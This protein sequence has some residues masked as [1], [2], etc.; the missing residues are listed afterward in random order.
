MFPNPEQGVEIASVE[1]APAGEED[2][3]LGADGEGGVGRHMA[4]AVVSPLLRL[5]TEVEGAFL[6]VRAGERP[7]LRKRPSRE[8]LQALITVRPYGATLSELISGGDVHGFVK[9]SQHVVSSLRA[10]CLKHRAL[11]DAPNSVRCFNSSHLRNQQV[12]TETQNRSRK[13]VCSERG[14]LSRSTR[15]INPRALFGISA[16]RSLGKCSAHR[17]VQEG[18]S[19]ALA[20]PDPPSR[21]LNRCAPSGSCTAS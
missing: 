14:L 1:I 16:S 10:S 5:S 17:R 19:T 9:R 3:E 13:V 8:T 7:S 4:R 6:T 21:P 2:E 20:V 15:L 12:I 11:S 18:A